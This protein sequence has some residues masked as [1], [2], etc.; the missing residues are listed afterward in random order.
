ML[1][2]GH[3]PQAGIGVGA[4]NL[5]GATARTDVGARTA[6]LDQLGFRSSRASAAGLHVPARTEPPL[7]PPVTSAI[8]PVRSRAVL[9]LHRRGVE[10]LDQTKQTVRCHWQLEDLP[11]PSGA[12]ASASA[13]AIA[14]GAPIVPPSPMPRNPPRLVGDSLSRWIVWIAG[15]SLAE[16]IT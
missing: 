11:P 12:S 7:A 6:A 4:I 1:K 10:V 15:I 9:L 14:A 5:Q 2:L 8:W 3:Y 16:G 13:F